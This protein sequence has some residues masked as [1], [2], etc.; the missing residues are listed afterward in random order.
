MMCPEPV[1]TDTS[2][3]DFH[4]ESLHR[5]GS[6]RCY[7]AFGLT[8]RA[9]GLNFIESPVKRGSRRTSEENQQQ[10]GQ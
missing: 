2:V 7:P 1:K 5:S 9:R 10:L 3:D 4:W 8:R 6:T